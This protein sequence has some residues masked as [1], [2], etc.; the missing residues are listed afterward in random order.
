MR[1]PT[2]PFGGHRQSG[3]GVAS[4]EEGLRKYANVQRLVEAA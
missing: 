3:I 2:L 4:A 1:I